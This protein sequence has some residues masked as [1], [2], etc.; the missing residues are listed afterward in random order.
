MKGNVI[1][2]LDLL[3]IFDV[4]LEDGVED[5]SFELLFF[6]ETASRPSMESSK[7]LIT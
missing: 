2:F 6:V 4:T 7:K 1:I 3:E 5:L